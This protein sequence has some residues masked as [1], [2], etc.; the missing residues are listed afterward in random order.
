M[1]IEC[2]HI[3]LNNKGGPSFIYS[4]YK[5]KIFLSKLTNVKKQDVCYQRGVYLYAIS[6]PGQRIVL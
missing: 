4:Y 5:C 2:K 6:K 3:C 1:A